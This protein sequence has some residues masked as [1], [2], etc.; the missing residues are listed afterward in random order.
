M[1]QLHNKSAKRMQAVSPT[2]PPSR[3]RTPTRDPTQT[4]AYTFFR[5]IA[6]LVYKAN[7]TSAEALDF[8]LFPGEYTYPS[9]SA[10]CSRMWPQGAAC[11]R[12]Q[13]PKQPHASTMR[14]RPHA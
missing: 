4:E 6:P 3:I 9:S 13:G 8:W 5:T 2:H 1:R 14:A 12:M 11:S 10:A 7:R